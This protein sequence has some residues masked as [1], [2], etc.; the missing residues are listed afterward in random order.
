MFYFLGLIGF[1]NT[2]ASFILLILFNYLGWEIYMWPSDNQTWFLMSMYAVGAC[3]I[4][5]CWAKSTIYLGPV[6]SFSLYTLM[7]FPFVIWFDIVVV[8]EPVEIST[9]Y[10]I[11]CSLILFVFFIITWLEFAEETE[12]EADSFKQMEV[13]NS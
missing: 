5:Y 8:N 1:Y 6:I 10:F 12:P 9:V 3:I 4:V 2:V 11:G 13:A 7:T